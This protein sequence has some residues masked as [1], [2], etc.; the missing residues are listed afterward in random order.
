MEADNVRIDA[1]GLPVIEQL[2]V[3]TTGNNVVVLGA[4]RV[5]FEA[6]AGT[7]AV[8]SGAL[9]LNG[10][11]P[12]H[13]AAA[14]AVASAPMDVPVPGRWTLRDLVR[15]NARLA[16]HPRREL[17]ALARAALHALGLDAMM[18][19]RLAAADPT[20]KRAAMIAAALATGAETI[21]V[22]DFTSGLPDAAGRALARMFVSASKRRRWIVFAAQLALSSPLGLH[23]DDAMLFVGGRLVVSGPPAEIAARDRT[24]TLRAAGDRE[25][26]TAALRD[27]G[28]KV[29]VEG[30]S[31]TVTLPEGVSTLE[32]V[33]MASAQ[34]VV[35]LELLP[36][37]G[38]LV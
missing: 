16:G 21:L 25:A 22:E 38:A 17:D 28:V 7:R 35:V 14:G 37:S 24:F 26:F 4:P 23:A 36:V 6:C 8:T 11:S 27:R 18:Q 32:L 30:G 2:S 31:L 15:E 33:R 19:T 5:L 1:G 34:S 12:Q 10:M 13:A 20:V 3:K 9:R 29:D